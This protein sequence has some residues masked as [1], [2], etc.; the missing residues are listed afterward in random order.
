MHE[1]DL[2]N[3][4]HIPESIQ[5]VHWCVWTFGSELLLKIK[6]LHSFSIK[7]PPTYVSLWFQCFLIGILC[8]GLISIANSYPGLVF[9]YPTAKGIHFNDNI[10]G[11]E[12][13]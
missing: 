3:N 8:S 2:P 9:T 10:G 11:L 7:S 1:S 13:K 12:L 5:V 4:D 6:L